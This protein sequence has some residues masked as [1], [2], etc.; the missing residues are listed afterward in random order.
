[1]TGRIKNQAETGDCSYAEMKGGK[2][3]QEEYTCSFNSARHGK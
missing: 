3:G 2:V 1:M